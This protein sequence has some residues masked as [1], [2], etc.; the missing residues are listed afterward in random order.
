L[1]GINVILLLLINKV[2]HD[3]RDI[4]KLKVIT[5]MRNLFWESES[6]FRR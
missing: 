1:Y 3:S 2:G 4:G 6:W 5:L